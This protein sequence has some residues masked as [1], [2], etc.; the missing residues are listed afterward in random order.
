ME[1]DESDSPQCQGEGGTVNACER[2][3]CVDRR[4]TPL[5]N[6]PVG[7]WISTS[8]LTSEAA[9]AFECESTTCYKLSNPVEA[10]E[11]LYPRA[12]EFRIGGMVGTIIGIVCFVGMIFWY[13]VIHV[14]N[15]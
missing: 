15:K 4:G 13:V 8:A 5:S 1:S 3:I 7:C 6:G 12:E 10:V 2:S 11:R 9:E 14:G